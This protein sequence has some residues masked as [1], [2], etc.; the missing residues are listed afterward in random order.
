MSAYRSIRTPAAEGRSETRLYTIGLYLILSAGA[1][2][3]V[4]PLYW[5]LLG[6][7]ESRERLGSPDAGW[8]PRAVRDF[9]T[10]NGREVPV[11]VFDDNA[12]SQT[13]VY[14]VKLSRETAVPVPAGSIVESVERH[15]WWNDGPR[16]R[17]VEII[18]H[19]PSSSSAASSPGTE[20]V[21]L[22][23]VPRQ[24]M[25]SIDQLATQTRRRT[26]W[27][28]FGLEIEVRSDAEPPPSTGFCR[29][30]W[31][32]DAPPFRVFPR[33][34]HGGTTGIIDWN[35]RPVNVERLSGDAG[36]KFWWVRLIR[37]TAGLDV[38]VNELRGDE[39]Q[40]T[41]LAGNPP[42][43]VRVIER[44]DQERT[45]VVEMLSQSEER[46][47]SS[48][49]LHF[50]T[51]RT[52]SATILGQ[53]VSIEPLAPFDPT[54]PAATV[55]VRVTSPIWVGYTLV[56]YER[57][58][59]PRW[60]NYARAWN[61]QTFGRFALNTLFI[62][63]LVVVGTVLSCGLVGY[64]FA[65]FHFPGRDALFMLLLATMM[66]PAQVTSIPTFVL[67]A[68]LGWLDSYL[69]LI[70]PHF[71]A[72]SAFF[73]FLFRQFMLS[74]PMDVE[75]AAR[76]DGCGP[77]RVWWLVLMPLCKPVIVTVALYA[78]IGVW[79]DFL[80]P[81][82]FIHSPEKQTVALGL[83][84]FKSA[85]QGADPHLIMAAA[86]MLMIPS[87]LLFLLAQKAFIRGVVVSGAKG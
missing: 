87:V 1:I 76:I 60:S 15:V 62:A 4:L 34:Y 12:L 43:E 80:N 17:R 73:V 5:L 6:S 30:T 81:L 22:V 71:L 24:I 26:L 2:P 39:Q 21:R 50:E 7:V 49:E 46:D 77:L 56:R 54:N 3:I 45:A 84:H 19:T 52:Y 42:L 37:P 72:A 32:D 14:G 61:E 66:I 68:R 36:G 38:P 78:F 31:S 53:A 79:N 27:Q 48:S 51:V 47:V 74:L 63:A 11:T 58:V 85:H 57:P 20:R 86:V 64:G 40:R 59:E 55:D 65:R 13:G 83:Q 75:D 9:I 69:P 25:V 44:N 8:L 33:A 35:G 16:R 67:F 70:V 10:V 41:I 82:L 29:I 18:P 28:V 23:D